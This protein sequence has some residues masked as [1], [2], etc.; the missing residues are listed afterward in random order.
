MGSLGE[1]G[2]GGETEES[3]QGDFQGTGTYI[4]SSQTC[5]ESTNII[6]WVLPTAL[7]LSEH[8]V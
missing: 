8:L 1:A 7:L 4:F 5:N 3:L 6:I 2:P